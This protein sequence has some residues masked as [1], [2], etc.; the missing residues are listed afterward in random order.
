MIY[1]FTKSTINAG[2]S[3]HR[4]FFPAKFIKKA[5]Y[6][7]EIITPPVYRK[8]I[9]R[10]KARWQY[11]KKILS[12][13][14]NDVVLLQ[15][16]I[17]SKWFVALMLVAK[18][19]LQ[20]QVVFDFDDAIWGR[21][22]IATRAFV[23]IADEFIVATHYLAKWSPLRGKPV[24]IIP[25]LIDY[26][27][28]EKYY[29]ENNGNGKIV[30]G[31]IG[32]AH[33]SLPNLRMLIP[34]FERLIRDQMQFKFK[35]VGALLSEAVYSSFRNIS[36][37]DVEFIDQ[38]D[39]GKEGEIQKAIS[40]F[41]IG[42]CPLLTNED[43]EARCSLK[44]LDYMSMGVPV[45]ISDIGENKYFIE[46]GVSGFLVQTEQEW[47]D[48][49]KLFIQNRELRKQTGR[50]GKERIRKLYSYQANINKYIKVLSRNSKARAD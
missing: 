25:N 39:W 10:S 40:S 37:L 26:E 35:I 3:R 50:N 20:P 30:I 7:L 16:P 48:S 5:G 46:N 6:D 2:G 47:F 17:F 45:V 21:N 32:G 49:L 22:P 14:K 44:V 38:L 15:T 8:D 41:D 43:N 33:H 36:G 19:I 4:A 18:Y 24:T 42:V 31:W 1:I 12:L 28:A 27:L 23:H 9:S 29:V 34:V 13:R 11:V